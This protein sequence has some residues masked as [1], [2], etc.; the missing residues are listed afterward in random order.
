MGEGI[1]KY[2][3][4]IRCGIVVN[5]LNPWTPFFLFSDEVGLF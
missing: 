2:Y 3:E 1:Q 4:K 5:S